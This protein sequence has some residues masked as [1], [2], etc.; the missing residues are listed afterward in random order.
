MRKVTLLFFAL[1][2]LAFASTTEAAPRPDW[3]PVDKEE[4]LFVDLNTIQQRVHV[5]GLEAIYRF[6]VKYLNPEE[7][8]R[9]PLRVRPYEYSVVT[10]EMDFAN[11]FYATRE[12]RYSFDQGYKEKV[13][14]RHK[15]KKAQFDWKPVEEG[16]VTGFV[17]EKMKQVIEDNKE[18]IADR[19]KYKPYPIPKD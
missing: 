4:T 6:Q 14:E 1:V 9:S 12:H 11:K 7:S 2:I 17:M 15:L 16:K 13:I 18:D 3:F 19:S 10:Y 5:D 8:D